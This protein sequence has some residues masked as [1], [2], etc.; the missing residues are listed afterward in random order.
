M[1]KLQRKI[2]LNSKQNQKAQYKF[3]KK[4]I[5]INSQFLKL[6]HILMRKFQK[7]KFRT[8]FKC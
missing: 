4:K 2:K 7:T 5:M 8:N 3:M 6:Y 1:K